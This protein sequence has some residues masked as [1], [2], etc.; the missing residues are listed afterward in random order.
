MET[1]QE[2][3]DPRPFLR[4]GRLNGLPEDTLIAACDQLIQLESRR[5]LRQGLRIAKNLVDKVAGLS[6]A[7]QLTAWR[8]YAR[9]LH[10]SGN[11]REAAGAYRRARTLAA[12]D[13]L[14]RGRIDRALIDVY[15]YIGDLKTSLQYSRSAVRTFTASGAASDLA[16]TRVNYANILHRQD[17]HREAERLYRQAAEFFETAGNRVAMAKCYYNRA[18]TLV[19]LFDLEPAE[20]L[21]EKARR[22]YEEDGFDLDACDSRYGLAWLNML[23]GKLH[24]ALLELTACEK[25]YH[26]AGD[27]R[28]EALCSLDRAEVYLQLGMYGDALTS[29]RESEHK[30]KKLSLQYESAKSALFRGQAAA[31]IGR[32]EEATAA[33]N[34]AKAGFTATENSSFVGATYLLAADLK[35]GNNRQWRRELRAA[36]TRFSRAQLPLWKALCD[37]KLAC[38]PDWSD[39]ALRRLQRN[40]AV[41][42]V[43]YL[44]AMW[45][46]AAGDQAYRKNDRARAN[47]RW[48]K[49]ADRL[50]L[51]RAQL[52]PVE[53]R[54]GINLDALSPHQRLVEAHA[55]SDPTKAACWSER[56]KT[57][58][59][60]A[61]LPTP[62]PTERRRMEDSLFGLAQQVAALSMQLSIGNSQRAVSVTQGR[63]I[64]KLQHQIREGLA[65]LEGTPGNF[66]YSIEELQRLFADCSGHTQIIQFHLSGDDILFFIH[67]N[68]QTRM[69]RIKDGRNKTMLAMERWRFVVEGQ[70]LE[71]GSGNAAATAIEQSVLSDFGNWLW[72]P[73][74]ISSQ[75][76]ELLIIPDGELANV[77]WPAILYG[78]RALGEVHRFVHT[79]SLRH[80]NQAATISP[81]SDAVYIFRGASDHLAGVAE[82]LSYLQERS[83]TKAIVH[84]PATRACWPQAGDAHIWH[85]SGHAELRSDNPFYSFLLLEDGP[86]FSA[87]FRLRQCKVHL[88]TLAA[89]RSGEQAHRPGHEPSG[90]VRSLLEMGARNVV[91]SRWTVADQTTARWMVHFYD[92]VLTGSSVLEAVQGAALALREQHP[93][94]L[95]WAAFAVHGAGK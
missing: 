35:Q 90:L 8:S 47:E 82:E 71:D 58:G 10:M 4:T 67:Q 17:R 24:V 49:A 63:S 9:L 30:F 40:R 23:R 50:D 28:G 78:S 86:L 95:H 31:Q 85:Y 45:Q 5:S 20:A 57:A 43:P 81:R 74:E 92:R 6:S 14:I 68:G 48:Q 25:Q 80:H 54:G 19:Q 76:S 37:L 27:P 73:L 29:A 94:A 79:P 3:L 65:S 18:N 36:R 88:V 60:W 70:L 34:R 33:M 55:S 56:S 21:Y 46:T 87:D 39:N 16:Q 59:L 44:Y 1:A 69:G 7:S 62:S 75:A 84:A 61:P 77:P 11:H 72:S 51:M 2:T 22:I 15:M 13:P 89:C 42:A 52:P 26:D 41:E 93:S 66:G 83:G 64:R 38:D 91:A 32:R 53:L 12:S